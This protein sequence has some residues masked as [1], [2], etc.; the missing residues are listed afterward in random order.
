MV[1]PGVR[2]I[3]P[4]SIYGEVYGG[5]KLEEEMCFNMW[6]TVLYSKHMF[7]RGFESLTRSRFQ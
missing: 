3:S 1:R 7:Y 4:V 6:L 5:K 2:E